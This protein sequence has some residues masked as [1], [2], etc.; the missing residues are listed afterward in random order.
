MS[1]QPIYD[2]TKTF[3]ENATYG[4][5]WEGTFP[6][7]PK[8]NPKRYSFLGHR[9]N[10][11]FGISACPLTH[12][13]RNVKLVSQLG[14]DLITYRSV[15]SIEWHGQI[16]PHWRYV[17]LPHPITVERLSE[18]VIASGQSFLGQDVSTANSFGI[19]SLK[20]E[21][22]QADFEIAK[23]FLMP[24][25]LLILS[26]MFTPEA[27]KDVID[28]AEAVARY[29]KETTAKIFEINLAH[30]N[31]GM[32]SLVYEDIETSV[33]IC[34][35]VK[36]AIGFRPLLAKIGYY[37]NPELLKEFLKKTRRII[38]GI[39]STNTY[40]MPIVDAQGK[41]VFPG[42]AKAGVSGAAIRNLSME[43]S[44]E[45]MRLK[46]ILGWKDLVVIGIGGVTKPEHIHKYLH[47]G[48]DAV[49]AAVGAW[50]D[51]YLASKY[52][53]SL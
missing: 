15:R 25:Q 29:A 16:Y 31:S 6:P 20:P 2:I 42:R 22:W 32:K 7:L 46:K 45:I 21:Y 37:K 39:S 14:Y 10:S 1:V 4:P 17:D 28:D 51:P 38:A 41:E 9:V 5:F 35:R 27:G 53:K 18:S 26:I 40:A 52:L 3:E 19:Q 36:K 44:K 49:Q 8:R 34:K 23:K 50:A 48:V 24:G 43:Q 33:A 12:G 13:S 30:P 11:L 47:L